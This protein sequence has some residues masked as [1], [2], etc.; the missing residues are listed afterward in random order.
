MLEIVSVPVIIGIVYFVMEVYKTLVKDA[1]AI[2]TS[3]IP[4]WAAILGLGLGVIAYFFVPTVMPADDI[5]TAILIGLASGLGAVGIHQVGK[6]I[7]KA[8]EDSDEEEK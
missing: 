6:Q 8:K 1:P 7:E 4:V 2:W 3:L 5:F